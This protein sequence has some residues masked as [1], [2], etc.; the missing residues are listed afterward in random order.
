MSVQIVNKDPMCSPL[1]VGLGPY[2]G[3]KSRVAS[4]VG[5]TMEM[6]TTL[7]T[8]CSEGSMAWLLGEK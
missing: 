6:G 2:M 4:P 1:W 5:L 7:H 3:D 8:E